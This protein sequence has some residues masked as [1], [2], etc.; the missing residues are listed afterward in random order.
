MDA[1]FRDLSYG[2]RRLRRE[3]GVALAA[4]LVTAIG[5]SSIMA[6]FSI[7]NAL[8]FAALPVLDP[9]RLISISRMSR[10]R[11]AS[12]AFSYPEYQRLRG[13][14]SPLSG[15]SAF[16]LETANLEFGAERSPL[17]V[18]F[19][20][21]NYFEVL[22]IHPRI[23]RF[24]LA[25]DNRPEADP[26][27][28]ISYEL[29]RHAFHED[30]D[31]IGKTIR[32]NGVPVTIVGVTPEHFNG[33]ISLLGM[34]I[35]STFPT[36][37]VVY[38]DR[39]LS[40]SNRSWLRLVARLRSHAGI[41]TAA[42]GLNTV[43]HEKGEH[44]LVEPLQGLVGPARGGAIRL[45][46]VLF[47]I[48]VVMLGVAATNTASL[49]LASTSV[50]TTELAF[51]AALGA[52]RF[53]IVRQLVTENLPIGIASGFL[54]TVL[55][56]FLGEFLPRLVPMQRSFPVR[57]AA[58]PHPDWRFFLFAFAA[59]F[60]TALFISLI[61]ALSV[62]REDLGLALRVTQGRSGR[63]SALH[64]G[65]LTCQVAMTFTLLVLT[66]LLLRT[67][68]TLTNPS[69]RLDPTHVAWAPV[70]ATSEKTGEGHAPEELV[71]LFREN[72]DVESVAL[73]SAI[74]LSGVRATT[75]VELSPGGPPIVV[76]HAV[77]TQEFFKVLRIPL[78]RGR[79]FSAD[80]RE[81]SPRVVVVS[82]TAA[83]RFW[84]RADPIGKEIWYGPTPLVV[85]GVVNDVATSGG[86]ASEPQLYFARA[87]ESVP[88]NQL[89]VR[90]RTSSAAAVRAIQSTFSIV[91]P[92]TPV[93]AVPFREVILSSMP[94]RALA[95][96]VGVLGA[97]SL[98]LS[99]IGMYAGA[100]YLAAQ[101]KREMAIRVALGAMPRDIF[102]AFVLSGLRVPAVALL[103]GAFFSVS[104][105]QLLR[106]LVVGVPA[107]DPISF[108]TAAGVVLAAVLIGS[109]SPALKL[110]FTDVA[111]TLREE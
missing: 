80:D 47:L 67:L 71:Q 23:G 20:S 42:A 109:F 61:P 103:L 41:Q 34:D 4:V 7:S 66:M 95:W 55:G 17:L 101:R 40:A 63:Q 48:S 46:T 11:G 83:E 97:V 59:S 92:N 93:T 54:G 110:A 78:V 104:F 13:T 21:E 26:V 99:A 16:G 82:R 77:V 107:W 32:M 49:L 102:G 74:P 64:S 33:T 6:V 8:L 105:T 30:H 75:S 52:G 72:P 70:N 14:A 65:F 73:A 56:W 35:W 69:Q 45:T 25:N 91:Q 31:V 89:L 5:I 27:A 2:M 94:Q 39:K 106:A 18:T 51:R 22:G 19:V 44:I 96:V 57:L 10:E 43:E 28:V 85:I 111:A 81:T 100:A 53:R 68:D 88:T 24:F 86:G 12:D 37:S 62:S 108:V 90:S 76:G 29:W 36:Y 84:P 98:V 9:D 50:R 79:T 38:P 87:Q 15:L 3:F 58:E 60:G 1:F